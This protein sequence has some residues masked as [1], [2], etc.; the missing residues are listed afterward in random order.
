[1]VLVK[2][3]QPSTPLQ[4]YMHLLAADELAK[5]EPAQV[6]R[7]VRAA[8]EALRLYET[9]VARA[10]YHSGLSWTDIGREVGISKQAARDRYAG[11]ANAH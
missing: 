8:R 11:D 9:E 3:P 6:L 5:T 2:S 7:W 1:M 4:A 10:A